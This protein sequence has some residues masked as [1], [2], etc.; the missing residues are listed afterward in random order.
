MTIIG[1]RIN[2]SRKPIARA[3]EERDAA[4]IRDEARKQLQ[5]GAHFIDVNTGAFAE[6]EWPNLKWLIE[7]VMAAGGT[8]LCIDSSDPEAVR[9]ALAICGSSA[10]V[11]SISA[12]KEKFSTVLPIIKE[13][14]CKVVALCLDDEGIPS[15]LDGKIE[16]GCTLVDDLIKNGIKPANIY[17]DPLVMAISTDKRSGIIALKTIEEI[18]KKYPDIHIICGL[19]NISFGLPVRKLMNRTFLVMGMAVG[20]DAFIFDPL[21]KQMM[22][23]LITATTLLGYDEYCADYIAAYRNNKLEM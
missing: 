11:N 22:A 19:S 5:A 4:F 2:S 6:K 15:E 17:V 16:V 23:N 7:T 14:D 10:M 20:L 3:I 9:E 13:Y 18:H 12:E 21:D 1:E 8:P